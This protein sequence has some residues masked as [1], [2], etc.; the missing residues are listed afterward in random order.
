VPTDRL[1]QKRS[2]VLV[3]LKR[4][5][6][7]GPVHVVRGRHTFG[8]TDAINWLPV[9]DKA[10]STTIALRPLQN[11]HVSALA[12]A[13][14]TEDAVPFGALSHAFHKSV[15]RLFAALLKRLRDGL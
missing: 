1:V 11:W 12:A 4:S 15:E 5:A 7:Q 2:L 6:G 8:R 10:K 14:G 3:D 9:T 13:L